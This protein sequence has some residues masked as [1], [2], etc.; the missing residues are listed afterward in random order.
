VP[1]R[2]G[3]FNDKQINIFGVES[4]PRFNGFTVGTGVIL[5]AVVFDV[6][7]LYEFGELFRSNEIVPG[8]DSTN[9]VVQ[10]SVRSTIHNQRFFAS[11]IYRFGHP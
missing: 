10:E 5:G 3:Y 7:Y 1:L 8:D 6:A 9:N 4:A 2:A 11:L